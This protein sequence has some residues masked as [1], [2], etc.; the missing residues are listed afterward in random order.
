MGRAL[1]MVSVSVN[2]WP[3]STWT[4][5]VVRLADRV[6]ERVLEGCGHGP[7]RVEDGRTC[8]DIRIRHSRQL[9]DNRDPAPFRERDLDEDAVEYLLG[10][11]Q[12]IPRQEPLKIVV[13]I[14]EAQDPLVPDQVLTEAVQSHFAHQREQIDRRLVDYVRRARLFLGVGLTAL[15]VFLS[16]A[17]LTASLTP[18]PWREILREGLVITGWVAMW[19]PLEVL[20]YDWWPHLRRKRTYDNLSRMRVEVLY[21]D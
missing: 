19:R 20:L 18:G 17:G 3:R 10:A 7:D 14:A 9:F 1:W 15:V 2:G 6:I 21:A 5:D 13:A 12:E 11:A 4:P 8:I 16:L